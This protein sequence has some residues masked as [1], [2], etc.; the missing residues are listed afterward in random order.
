[1][2]R[3]GAHVLSGNIV[4]V[5]DYGYRGSSLMRSWCKNKFIKNVDWQP[6]LRS[7]TQPF[8]TF[9]ARGHGPKYFLK[10]WANLSYNQFYKIKI[11]FLIS[12][13]FPPVNRSES[14]AVPM[15]TLIAYC[16]TSQVPVYLPPNPIHYGICANSLLSMKE[17]K[18]YRWCTLVSSPQC[19]LYQTWARVVI[20]LAVSNMKIQSS[21][22]VL[23]VQFVV[24]QLVLH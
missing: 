9:L 21:L 13:V 16:F 24:L 22:Q 1:M 2:H 23:L 11:F 5:W 8:L 18:N 3:L 7:K 4:F 15:K 6:P 20:V 19:S 14:E 12:H 10:V 17:T